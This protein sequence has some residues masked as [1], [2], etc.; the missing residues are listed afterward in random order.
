MIRKKNLEIK[1]SKKS[2]L[3]LICFTRQR[4]QKFQPKISFNRIISHI[5]PYEAGSKQTL[6]HLFTNRLSPVCTFYRSTV[7]WAIL[8]YPYAHMSSSD[9]HRSNFPLVACPPQ[10]CSRTDW[11]RGSRWEPIL[12]KISWSLTVLSKGWLFLHGQYSSLTWLTWL[13]RAWN[14]RTT[15]R[16]CGSIS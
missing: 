13:G 3:P 4:K 1:M 9:R 2:V 15:L 10:N 6:A 12:S 14:F 11:I 7:S 5:G 8:M 16:F